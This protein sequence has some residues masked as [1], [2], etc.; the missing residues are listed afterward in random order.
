MQYPLIGAYLQIDNVH[1]LPGPG[2]GTLGVV[3]VEGIPVEGDSLAVVGT[4]NPEVGIL[5]VESILG[6]VHVVDS[7][8]LQYGK[9]R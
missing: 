6:P 7:Q 8:G 9:P 1:R 3:V 2:W 4:P 5:V